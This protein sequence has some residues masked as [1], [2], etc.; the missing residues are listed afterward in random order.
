LRPYTIGSH[1]ASA[2]QFL[3]ASLSINRYRME[4]FG[5]RGEIPP[6]PRNCDARTAFVKRM[7]V[8]TAESSH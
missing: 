8:K 1:E 4:M 5:K 3:R 7:Q 2:T 6:L